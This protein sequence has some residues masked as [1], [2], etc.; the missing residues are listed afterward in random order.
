MAV[1]GGKWWKLVGLAGLV[2]VA[3]TGVVA[4]RNERRRRNY[5]PDEVRSVL[6]E[7]YARTLAA[8]DG[9][10]DVPLAEVPTGPRAR[11]RAVLHR[12]RSA[13][14]RPGGAS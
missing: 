11:I 12:V 3:A 13:A 8:R 10:P 5:T 14:R 1:R 6:H 9:R 2:G 4:T 7:R